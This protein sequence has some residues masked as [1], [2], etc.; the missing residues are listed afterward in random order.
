MKYLGIW[1]C[2]AINSPC[3]AI[4]SFW[5]SANHN[6]RRPS[7]YISG[8]WPVAFCLLSVVF[9]LFY[10]IITHDFP[11]DNPY[12]SIRDPFWGIALRAFKATIQQPVGCAPDW[13]GHKR[14]EAISSSHDPIR[15][16]QSILH[17]GLRIKSYSI[18]SLRH[19]RD[20]AKNSQNIHDICSGGNQGWRL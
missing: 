12:N 17:H 6:T 20:Q 19:H 4:S 2:P 10:W 3:I 9:G 11:A 16:K 5:Q 14:Q 13:R 15:T 7:A 8:L 18:Q 1:Q